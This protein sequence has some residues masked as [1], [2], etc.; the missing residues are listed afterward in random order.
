MAK[1]ILTQLKTKNST[2]EDL[3][4]TI[5]KALEQLDFDFKKG[6]NSIV[7]KPNLCYYW[8][9]ST[10]ETTD[11]RVVA[12]IIDELR[13]M[14]GKNVAI[15]VAEADAS[16][17]KT[18][19]SF[20][21]LGY[22]EMCK[23]KEVNLVN[24]CEGEIINK[25][26]KVGDKELNLPVNTILLKADLVVNVPKLK[27]HNVMGFT[28]AMKNMFGAI[29]KPY[30]Y[31][32]HKV[33]AHAIVGI[34]KEIKSDIVIVD[35]IV[36]KGRYPKKLGVIMTANDVL[37]NDF[38]AARIMSFN[39]QRV[40]YLKLAAREHVG[41]A[42]KIDIIEDN[43]KMSEVKAAFP[44]YSHFRHRLSWRLQLKLLR[45]YG[46]IVKDVIPPVLED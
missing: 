44:C 7:I 18:K 38:V 36:A 33:L 20:D 25:T 11:P 13:N 5:K 15:S 4:K 10:G 24:L 46:R 39:P 16:A 43:V 14:I 22:R 40:K 42:N 34:N 23:E 28:C 12:T 3:K 45:L 29:A 8:D 41:E 19:Y 31:S 9:Y 32:Y 2:Q 1:V 27:T 37:A 17:M 21:V 35:G 30:K 6:I 26:A